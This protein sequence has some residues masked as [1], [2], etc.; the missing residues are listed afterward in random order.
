MIT[1]AQNEKLTL[2]RKLAD[3]K[4]RARELLFAAEGEDLVEAADRAG[5]EPEFVLRA[6]EDVEPE[7]LRSA[8]ALGSGSRVVGVYRQWFSEAGGKL[9]VYLHAVGDPGNVGTLIRAAHALA[10]GPVV[11]G[12]D[13]ADPFSP[14]AVRASMGSIF[15][16]PPARATLAELP[17][18]KL[19]L[20]PA[21]DDALADVALEAPVVVC[22]GAERE[23][24][25]AEVLAAVDRRA[26]IP[27]NADGPDSLNVAM[28]GTVAL[29]ELGNRITRHV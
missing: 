27:V 1:S 28:A 25:P 12:P 20:D 13:C 29:Y 22:L 23:G 7:L 15:A 9:S 21:A 11:L 17:G 24:L 19:A 18:A 10:D 5:W 26:R 16:R 6:G 4:H 14:K 2:I 3:R 8:S